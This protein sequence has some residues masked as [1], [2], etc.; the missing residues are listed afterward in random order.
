M[1]TK[2]REWKY[3]FKINIYKNETMKG[4]KKLF[5]PLKTFKGIE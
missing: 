5:Q 2:I 1:Q 3:F 4:M